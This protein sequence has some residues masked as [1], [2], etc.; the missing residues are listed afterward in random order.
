MAKSTGVLKAIATRSEKRAPMELHDQ[1]EVNAESGLSCDA[2]RKPGRAQV[3]I[4]SAEKWTE[5]NDVLGADLPWT[6]RR[7]NL[8]VSG[9]SLEPDVGARLSIGDVI[10]EVTMETDPCERMDEQHAG[11]RQAL[12]INARCG[13]RCRIV[14]GGTIKAG[15]AVT[16]LLSGDPNT[17]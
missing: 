5:A 15:C 11:L 8:L 13:V 10:L 6:F 16:W 1:I 4:V 2:H 3:T 14:Q 17:H 7:A 9:I 12:E